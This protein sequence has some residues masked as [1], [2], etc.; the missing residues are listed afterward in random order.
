MGQP[1]AILV[2]CEKLQTH[3]NSELKAV[4]RP[5]IAIDLLTVH[6]NKSISLELSG[7]L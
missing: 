1:E 4:E 5:G 6:L 7:K 2:T 3:Y